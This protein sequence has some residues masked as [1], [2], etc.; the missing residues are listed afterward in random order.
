MCYDMVVKACYTLLNHNEGDMWP[1]YYLRSSGDFMLDVRGKLG[2]SNKI[3]LEDK[4]G[5]RR[6]IYS[7]K[8]PNHKPILFKIFKENFNE[9]KEHDD[10]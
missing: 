2:L 3:V 1:L 4:K 10:I 7:M 9:M 8:S 5:D 6:T